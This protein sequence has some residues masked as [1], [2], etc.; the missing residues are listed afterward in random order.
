MSKSGTDYPG[1]EG[2]E[3]ARLVGSIAVE[4]GLFDTDW[5]GLVVSRI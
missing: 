4:D 5:P 2:K 1:D 3:L